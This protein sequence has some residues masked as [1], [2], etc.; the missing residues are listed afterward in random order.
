MAEAP[1]PSATVTAEEFL[2][3][4]AAVLPAVRERAQEAE[5][6]RRLPEATVA[7]LELG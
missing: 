2:R 5:H 1:A 6:L 3:R 7:D 4:A